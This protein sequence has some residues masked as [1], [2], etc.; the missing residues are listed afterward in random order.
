M[1]AMVKAI[2]QSV[3]LQSV[4]RQNVVAPLAAEK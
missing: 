3:A 4:V 2:L 1:G